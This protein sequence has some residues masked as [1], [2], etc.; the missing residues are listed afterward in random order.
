VRGKI[1]PDPA[2]RR[3]R[4]AGWA[5]VAVGIAAIL[6]AGC[7]GGAGSTASSGSSASGFSSYRSCLQQHGVKLPTSRPSGAPGSGGGFGGGFGGPPS[8]GSSAFQKAIQACASLRPSG[9]FGGGFGGGTG[10]F[11]G[12][13]SA[14]KAFRSC[15][16][17][18]GEPVPTTRPTSPP[19]AGSSPADRFL[20]G[21]NPSNSR[22][23]A[24]LKGC[25]S[26]LSSF[27]NGSGQATSD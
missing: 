17:A 6:V 16:A 5:C 20:N 26:K 21:L 19:A 9:G 25:E 10:G 22:V 13:A 11:G 18:H 23:A 15:M 12:F 7:G 2:R 14:L 4:A 3:D 24:A 8:T 1:L 27:L